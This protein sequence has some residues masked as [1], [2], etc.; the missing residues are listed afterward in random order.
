MKMDKVKVCPKCGKKINEKNFDLCCPYCGEFFENEIKNEDIYNSKIIETSETKRKNA[1]E[2]AK[3][4]YKSNLKSCYSSWG[5]AILVCLQFMITPVGLLLSLAG[6]PVVVFG[7]LLLWLIL[8]PIIC[9]F[10]K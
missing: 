2:A 9:M 8:I 4:V 10:K 1:K 3:R 7:V 6:L 5:H